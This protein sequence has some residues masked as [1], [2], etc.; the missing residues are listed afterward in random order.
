MA[1]KT[2]FDLQLLAA[3]LKQAGFHRYFGR[4]RQQFMDLWFIAFKG[5]VSES[6]LRTKFQQYTNVPPS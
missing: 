4:R 2:G 1:H 6:E 3:R 5:H